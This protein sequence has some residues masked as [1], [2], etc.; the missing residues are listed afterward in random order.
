MAAKIENLNLETVGSASPM[1]IWEHISGQVH[2][3]DINICYTNGDSLEKLGYISTKLER[4]VSFDNSEP[5]TDSVHVDGV[6]MTALSIPQ[7]FKQA[8]LPSV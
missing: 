8:S 4:I 2:S 3:K 5:H 1:H 7:R 6:P